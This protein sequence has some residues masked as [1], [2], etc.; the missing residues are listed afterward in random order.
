MNLYIS[1]CTQ[2][3]VRVSQ[4]PDRATFALHTV[5]MYTY[6]VRAAWCMLSAF[7]HDYNWW[8][9]SQGSAVYS[10]ICFILYSRFHGRRIF[11]I[12]HF[13]RSN[14][15]TCRTGICARSYFAQYN[16]MHRTEY[17][18]Q[19][20]PFSRNPVCFNNVSPGAHHF[21]LCTSTTSYQLMYSVLLD[22][23]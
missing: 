12:L 6:V 21:L 20:R 19:I 13:W 18:I 2:Q 1:S 17:W 4:G 9:I 3:Y 10:Y 16:Q 8:I 5:S 14:S 7:G 23:V 15:R 22:T 11:G